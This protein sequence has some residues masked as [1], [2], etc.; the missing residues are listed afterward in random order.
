MATQPQ[1]PQRLGGNRLRRRGVF[2][3]DV[4]AD[5]T[6]QALVIEPRIVS[7]RIFGSDPLLAPDFLP[8]A[9]AVQRW[10]GER[11]GDARKIVRS[12]Q[13]RIPPLC[14]DELLNVGEVARDH[15]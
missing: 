5:R 8:F 9:G 12:A 4:L 15:P 2:G 11:Y 10:I 7:I 6:A 14:L 13:G 3:L 1:P